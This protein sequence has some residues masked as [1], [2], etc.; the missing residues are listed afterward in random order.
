MA[1]EAFASDG[2]GATSM[3]GIA[4]RLG[5]S[6]AT[7]Y[8]YFPSKEQLFG[9]VL[10][11]KC[12]VVLG[13][14]REI[15]CRAED[16]ETLLRDFGTGFLVALLEPDALDVHRMIHGDGARFPEAA[17]MFFSEGPEGVYSELSRVFETFSARGAIVCPEPRLAAEQFIGM[18]RADLHMRVTLG[19]LPAPDP[20]E[21]Q[22]QVA[23][24]ARIFVQGLAP[25]P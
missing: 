7:L 17:R 2:Y 23:H 3:S 13:P 24:A 25:R 8:K 10:T 15:T 11:R 22:R 9:E 20:A 6:K 14:L 19:I 1:A 21:V 16:L 18:I 12:D 5:G 4:A